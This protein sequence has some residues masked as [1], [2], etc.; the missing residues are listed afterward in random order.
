MS[1]TKNSLYTIAKIITNPNKIFRPTNDG[2]TSK[3]DN[4]LFNELGRFRLGN[5]L[6]HVVENNLHRIIHLD[7]L[8]FEIFLNRQKRKPR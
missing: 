8:K 3:E 5:A 2:K 7:S 1:S 4:E 6:E